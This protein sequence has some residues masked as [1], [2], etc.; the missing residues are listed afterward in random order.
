MILK[1]AFLLVVLLRSQ[2][3]T[4]LFVRKG[5]K[6]V[7]LLLLINS[8]LSL[9]LVNRV[10]AWFWSPHP[11]ILHRTDTW[12]H[13]HHH[14]CYNFFE[15]KVTALGT[16]FKLLQSVLKT[17]EGVDSNNYNNVMQRLELTEQFNRWRFLQELLD[18]DVD[19]RD[20]NELLYFVFQAYLQSDPNQRDDSSPALTESMQTTLR[21]LLSME[22][23]EEYSI[24]VFQPGCTA[25]PSLDANGQREAALI[26]NYLE[27]L[28]PDPIEQKD[29]YDGLWDTI[30]GLHGWEGVRINRQ[31]PCKDWESRC[32][33]ARVLIWFDFLAKGVLA[34]R[35]TS[36]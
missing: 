25:S 26:M 6:H 18:G 21:H 19:H 30:E 9:D 17:S 5:I 20:V 36:P 27:S 28:L 22:N 31:N 24:P 33:V 10:E 23:V 4:E 12:L 35:I 13:T 15:R 3:S 29:A 7:T 8:L 2:R 34:K 1:L 14:C 11:L 16:S 32:T